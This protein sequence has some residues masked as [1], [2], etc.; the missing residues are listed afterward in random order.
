LN[1]KKLMALSGLLSLFG[2][3]CAKVDPTTAP[4]ME[5]IYGFTMKDIDGKDV[6]LKKFEG[7]VL[8]VVNVASKCGLTP[9]YD[10]LEKLYTDHEKA[11]LTVL[12]FP[13]NDFMGQE[14]GT[15][16]EIKSFCTTKFNVTFP[17]FSKISVK[18]NERN[19]LY[20]WMIARSGKLDE[21]EWNFAK[22]LIGR[23]GKVKKRFGPRTAPDA[24]EIL[25][26]I[27]AE[28]AVK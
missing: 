20:T 28:L 19:E 1:V 24:P 4:Q 25:E 22:F 16:A 13:A 2:I 7:R 15:D 12:G 3:G 8:L 11:G 9:Q 27:K 10:A 23:D 26:A 18:G 17:M 21:I 14:P 5:T 6:P